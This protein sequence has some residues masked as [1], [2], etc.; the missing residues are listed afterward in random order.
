MPTTTGISLDGVDDVVSKTW[1]GKT[2]SSDKKFTFAAWFEL[3]TGPVEQIYSIATTQSGT[4]ALYV[5]LAGSAGG[6]GGLASAN[7]PFVYFLGE[8]G[9]FTTREGAATLSYDTK[10][11]LMVVYDGAQATSANRLKVWFGPYN[12]AVSLQSWSN[13]N[14]T[15]DPTLNDTLSHGG[16]TSTS[17]DGF[18]DDSSGSNFYDGR[19]ADVYWL[20]NVALAD[21]SSLLNNYASAAAPGTY[22]GSY[23]NTGYHLDFSNAGSLGADSSGNSNNFTPAGSPTQLTGYFAASGTTV[24]LAATEAPDTAAFAL[25]LSPVLALAATEAADTAAVVVTVGNDS[26]ASLAATEAPDVAAIALTAATTAS[27]TTTEAPDTVSIV[28]VNQSATDAPITGG[29]Y[30]REH[31]PQYRIHPEYEDAPPKK[32]RRKPD[33]DEQP[34][35]IAPE[36]IIRKLGEVRPAWNTAAE[37][38]RSELEAAQA[39]KARAERIKAIVQADDEWLM[40]G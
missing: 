5:G 40:T 11:F 16:G 21:P 36:P 9:S 13:T 32:K 31:K 28:A 12:G 23:G 22:A 35:I 3:K 29:G 33:P 6:P 2:P 8:G 10:Y 26:V 19:V 17:Y 14:G 38:M 34:F 20:D 1:T 7:T 24:A 4:Y 18:G 39:A 15:S 30:Y 25:D 37:L 27:L